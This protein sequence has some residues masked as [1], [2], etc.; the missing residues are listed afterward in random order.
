MGSRKD[1][2]QKRKTRAMHLLFSPLFAS[3]IWIGGG[4][5]GLVLVIVVVVLLLS[6]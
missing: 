6:G 3:A 5:L 1:R 2:D 4:S